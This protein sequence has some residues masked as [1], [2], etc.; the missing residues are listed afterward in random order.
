MKTGRNK[1]PEILFL[2]P[3]FQDE[4]FSTFTLGYHLGVGY[5]L[6]YLKKKGVYAKQFTLKGSVSL[7]ELIGMILSQKSKIIG[8]TCY[9]HNYY[10]IKIRSNLY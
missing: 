8:F 9:D 5:I 1:F 6:A 7:H 10:I 3:G 2:F 4:I